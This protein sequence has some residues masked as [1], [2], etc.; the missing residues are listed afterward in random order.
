MMM[1]CRK[2]R[3]ST[4]RIIA[5]LVA[6]GSPLAASQAE[7]TGRLVLEFNRLEPVETGCRL[8]FVIS[9]R[10]PQPLDQVAFEFAFLNKDGRLEKLSV[11]DFRDVPA[12]KSRVRQ[13]VIPGIACAAIGRL[14]VNDVSTC[15]AP[16]EGLCHRALETRN[17]TAIEFLS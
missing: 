14:I 16:G 1:W 5:M 12:G 8:S 11:L 15:K 9:S 4:V 3:L 17:K 6:F 13:F 2:Y 10:L 7:E